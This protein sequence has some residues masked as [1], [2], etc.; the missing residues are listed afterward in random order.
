[1]RHLLPASLLL[2]ACAVLHAADIDYD[3]ELQRAMKLYPPGD[4]G[5]IPVRRFF[6]TTEVSKISPR[7]DLFSPV[8]ASNK[9]AKTLSSEAA[10]FF[11][12]G[13][14]DLAVKRY[15]QLLLIEPGNTAA[16][17]HL[18]DIAQLAE[19]YGDPARRGEAAKKYEAMCEEVSKGI[20]PDDA[21]RDADR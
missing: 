13:R 8:E 6:P 21:K 10:D 3:A 15:K 11:I 7:I 1:M 5:E 18:Y 19:L 4:Y 9:D 12:S 2:S 20:V 14:W 16:K 17:A